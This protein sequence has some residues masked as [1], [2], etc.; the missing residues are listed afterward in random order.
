MP[1]FTTGK[2]IEGGPSFVDPPGEYQI[3]VIDAR[4]AMS[5][6]GNEMIEITFRILHDD[7]TEGGKM[8]EN[9]VFME[10]TKWRVDQFVAACG[11]HPGEG[12]D[13]DLYPALMFG[14]T[15]RARI[16]IESYN[17]KDR[18]KVDEYLIDPE[19]VG[20]TPGDGDEDQVPW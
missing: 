11:K 20:A 3:K 1:T 4:E 14:W 15:C 9:L 17:G 16:K 8:Y 19:T 18:N 7:G 10:K 13:F 2:P 6:A 12:K 5:K